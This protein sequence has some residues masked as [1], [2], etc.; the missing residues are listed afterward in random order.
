MSPVALQEVSGHCTTGPAIP[1]PGV[2]QPAGCAGTRLGYQ[3]YS[4]SKEVTD[5]IYWAQLLVAVRSGGSLQ[6][7][8]HSNECC[9]AFVSRALAYSH[10]TNAPIQ[11]STAFDM[12]PGLRGGA[13]SESSSIASGN[14]RSGGRRR[15][16]SSSMIPAPIWTEMGRHIAVPDTSRSRP[17]RRART[18]T[19]AIFSSHVRPDTS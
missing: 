12:M 17:H 11:G 4:S 2:I 15:V 13:L 19:S 9:K 7:E 3:D 14:D 5:A 16:R 6:K 10:L 1:E 8:H 18:A